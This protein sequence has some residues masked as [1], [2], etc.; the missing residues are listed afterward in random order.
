MRSLLAISSLA[1][2]ITAALADGQSFPL[3]PI[4][5]PQCAGRHNCDNTQLSQRRCSTSSSEIRTAMTEKKMFA[6]SIHAPN[7][8]RN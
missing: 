1:I 3:D 8:R 6:T 7:S 4:H 5:S 2:V